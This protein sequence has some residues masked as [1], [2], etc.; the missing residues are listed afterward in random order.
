LLVVYAKRKSLRQREDCQV[1][2]EKD[3]RFKED[4]ELEKGGGYL[5]TNQCERT[6]QQ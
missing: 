1:V 6:P 5:T 3:E 2:E 4:G